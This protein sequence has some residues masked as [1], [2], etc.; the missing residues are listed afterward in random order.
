MV[1]TIRL[2]VRR[3][4]RALEL[5]RALAAAHAALPGAALPALDVTLTSSRRYSGGYDH[6]GRIE[7]SRHAEHLGLALL[8]ELGHA[9]DHLL[10]GRD[11]VWGSETPELERWWEAVRSSRAYALL[12]QACREG[13]TGYWPTR[14]ESFARSF[15]QWVAMRGGLHLHAEVARRWERGRQWRTDDFA[16]IGYALDDVLA[17]YAPPLRSAG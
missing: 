8:H 7:V 10:L 9:V 16:R 3:G 11:G 5:T 1:E 17:P 6:T 12:L 4:P 14:R 13:E 15:S 2:P